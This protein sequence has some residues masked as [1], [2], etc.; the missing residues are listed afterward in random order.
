MAVDADQ[1]SE[2]TASDALRCGDEPSQRGDDRSSRHPHGG[3][4]EKGK[5]HLEPNGEKRETTELSE[6]A[7][8]GELGDVQP[9]QTGHPYRAGKDVD[10]LVVRIPGGATRGCARQG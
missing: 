5:H 1:D 2:L 10:P 7:G 4:K 8:H 9:G 6:R 3:D